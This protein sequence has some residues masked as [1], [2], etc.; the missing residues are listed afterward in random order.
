MD[1]T[2]RL[3]ACK[4]RANARL[5]WAALATVVLAVIVA[6]TLHI[7]ALESELAGT[8]RERG[9]QAVY[10]LPDALDADTLARVT[11]AARAAP[12]TRKTTP[13]RSGEAVS[14]H[15]LRATPELRGVLDAVR[16]PAFLQRVHEATGMRLQLV[17]RTDENSV[18]VLRYSRAG[19]GIDAHRDGNVYI[20]SRWVGILV[21]ADDGDSVLTVGDEA[22]ATPEPGTL[23]L[24]E[25]DV[26][27]HAVSRRTAAG[28]RLVLN[29]LLCDVCAPKSDVFS[30]MWSSLVSHAAFY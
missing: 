5:A 7:R 11:A 14:A 25:G 20:G 8:E 9:A 15:T 30:K 17:P 16:D 12:V 24:F 18:S 6:T 2:L 19:D 4:R 21:L 29:I 27:T 28:E 23:L 26:A 13:M 1:C 22:I 10:V 3:R